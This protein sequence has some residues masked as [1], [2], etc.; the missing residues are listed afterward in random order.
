MFARKQMDLNEEKLLK[1][2]NDI[3]FL[4][5]FKFFYFTNSIGKTIKTASINNH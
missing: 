3:Y 1:N 4:L 5:F 2:H